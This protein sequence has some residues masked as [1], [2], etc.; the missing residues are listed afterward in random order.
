VHRWA[1]VA[2]LLTEGAPQLIGGERRR[3]GNQ[4]LGFDA[5]GSRL[6]R[7]E[8]CRGRIGWRMGEGA[9]ERRTRGRRGR[10]RGGKGGRMKKVGTC[11]CL[12]FVLFRSR[13]RLDL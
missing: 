4:G 8:G 13:D 11:F 9:A 7:V 3:V 2:G 1:A 5:E 10:T 6:A 12:H